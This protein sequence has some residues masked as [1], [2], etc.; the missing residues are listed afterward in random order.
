ML[1]DTIKWALI[2]F[3]GTSIL[4]SIYKNYDKVDPLIEPLGDD[5]VDNKTDKM[6]DLGK[7]PT[8]EEKKQQ[9]ESDKAR[10]KL[11]PAQINSNNVKF[12]RRSIDGINRD[13]ENA[14]VTLEDSFKKIKTQCCS[15]NKNNYDKKCDNP[16]TRSLESCKQDRNKLC[17]PCVRGKNPFTCC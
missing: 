17:E 10:A 15:I 8:D 11:T 6:A 14:R 7:K 16:S 9:E 4:Y 3:V 2:L 12:L 13:I 5:N 1:Y